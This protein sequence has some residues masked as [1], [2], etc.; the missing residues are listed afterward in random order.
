MD[1]LGGCPGFVGQAA[2]RILKGLPLVPRAQDDLQGHVAFEL[3]VPCK[4]DGPHAPLPEEAYDPH[5]LHGAADVVVTAMQ[6]ASS[7]VGSRRL[8][9]RAA[10]EW[11]RAL[12]NRNLVFYP[13]RWHPITV[14]CRGRSI[15]LFPLGTVP[16]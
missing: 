11:N 10:N 12:P 14:E 4:V 8:L 9:L 5:A 2:G 15:L 1:Y 13:T 7:E 3:F 6:P 16:C